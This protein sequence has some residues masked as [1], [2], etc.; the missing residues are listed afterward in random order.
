MQVDTGVL[1]G[2]YININQNF[3][4]ACKGCCCFI[5]CVAS[6]HQGFELGICSSHSAQAVVYTF[7]GAALGVLCCCGD[8]A[9]QLYTLYWATSLSQL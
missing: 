3:K 2:H 5:D 8:S 7:S 4:N 9:V 1:L 6:S